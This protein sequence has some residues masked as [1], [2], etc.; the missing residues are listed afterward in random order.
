VDKITAAE[1]AQDTDLYGHRLRHTDDARDALEVYRSA[2]ASQPDGCVKI[3]AIGHLKALYDLLKSP[4]DR[5]SPLSG[6][7]LV[8]A[9][10]AEFVVMGG[11]YPACGD[12]PEWNFGACDSALWTRDVL[13][14]W[15]TAIVF[16]GFEIGFGIVT[17]RWLAEGSNRSAMARTYRGFN[18][19]LADGSECGRF[20]WDQTAVLYAARGL[21][22][23]GLA[24]WTLGPRGT[25]DVD[26]DGRNRWQASPSGT[27]HYLVAAMPPEELAK[28]IDGLMGHR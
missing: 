1:I 7:E 5:H 24:Y 16:T 28:V 21:Q 15:P 3:V 18:T 22:H 17:G 13:R 8:T 19:W 23:E 9:K 25:V 20:S 6:R 11:Q 2:L 14:E 4:P 27:H 10:V 12:E 26:A